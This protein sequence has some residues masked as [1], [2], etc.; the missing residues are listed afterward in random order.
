MGRVETFFDYSGSPDRPGAVPLARWLTER[1]AD[2]WTWA[3]EHPRELVVNGVQ[4]RRFRFSRDTRPV[5][6]HRPVSESGRPAE[7]ARSA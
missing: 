5:Q 4:V 1:F 7:P 3:G 2:G 6:G